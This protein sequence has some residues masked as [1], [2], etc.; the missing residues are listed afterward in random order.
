MVGIYKI[1]NIINDKFYI[2][3]SNN[4]HKR[5]KNHFMNLR[6][7]KHINKI[8]QNSYNK[9][10]VECFTYEILEIL[11][12][13]IT[14]KQLLDIEQK[15]IDK[16]DFEKLFNLATKTTI[17]GSDVLK[18]PCYLLNLKGEIF[19]EFD[20]LIDISKYLNCAQ[21][22]SN[23][24]NNSKILFKQ[25][26]VVTKDFYENNL[27]LILSWKINVYKKDDYLNHY[28]FDEISR[29]F[30]VFDGD[31]ISAIVND[32]KTAIKLSKFLVEILNEK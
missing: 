20:C 15:Y 24:Y 18:Q 2:G 8:L 3:S 12:E 21:I 26:R 4:I 19:K 10:G 28:K 32:E 31:N 13:N 14:R 22:N 5:I 29:K 30:I 1:K 25:Y 16:Y 9:Y 17:G 6:L 7:N 11:P 23:R 27:E